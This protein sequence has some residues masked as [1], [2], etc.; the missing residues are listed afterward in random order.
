[1]QLAGS[2]KENAK[3]AIE[4]DIRKP[5]CITRLRPWAFSLSPTE[6]QQVDSNGVEWML[7]FGARLAAGFNG[8]WTLL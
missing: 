7:P 8:A 2:K 3:P 1:M 6:C 5:H 4:E